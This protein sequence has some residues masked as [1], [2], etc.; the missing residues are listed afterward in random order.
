MAERGHYFRNLRRT[1][2]GSWR[3]RKLHE[4]YCAMR[5]EVPTSDARTL[6]SVA[7]FVSDLKLKPEL[8]AGHLIALHEG[9]WIGLGALSRK[10]HAP[11]ELHTD[12][13]GV[14]P[15]YRRQGVALGIITLGVAWAHSLGVS[16][17]TTENAASNKAIIALMELIGFEKVADWQLFRKVY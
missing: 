8:F 2:G 7:G 12:I 4:L 11:A 16:A 3:G 9:R 13:L 5:A 14:M 15:E 6:P 10:T 17:V 1:D